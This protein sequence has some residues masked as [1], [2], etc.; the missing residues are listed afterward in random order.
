[1]QLKTSKFVDFQAKSE[2]A[3]QL[4]VETLATVA[5]QPERN[6]KTT[7]RLHDCTGYHQQNSKYYRI[8][9]VVTNKIANTRESDNLI[10]TTN[11][12]QHD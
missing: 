4:M 12:M 10:G 8:R 9:Q 1:M 11:N 6:L 7:I 3:A 5:Y 2:S